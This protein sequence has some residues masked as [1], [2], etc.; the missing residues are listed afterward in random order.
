MK[1]YKLVSS[2]NPSSN[3]KLFL[4][5]E[6]ALYELKT[7]HDDFTSRRWGIYDLTDIVNDSFSFRTGGFYDNEVTWRIAEIEVNDQLPS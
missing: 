7:I 6:M 4:Y 3:E 2:V 1:I 5:K